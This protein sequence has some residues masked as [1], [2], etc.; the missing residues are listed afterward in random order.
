MSEGYDNVADILQ[1]ANVGFDHLFLDEIT[2]AKTVF[3]S[4]DSPFHL[5]G[6]GVCS[7]LE[8]SLGMESTMMAEANA[9]LSNAEAHAKRQLKSASKANKDTH[10]FP[11]GTLWELIHADCII[12]LGLTQALSE[13][14]TGYLQCLYSINTAHSKYL[15]LYKVVFPGGLDN[16]S[17]PSQ[18]SPPS[19]SLTPTIIPSTSSR[20]SLFSRFLGNGS[21]S[22]VPS[23]TPSP[24]PR[25]D[26]PPEET[27]ISGTAFGYGLFNLV[28]SMF[29]GKVKTVVGFFGY[30]Y[31]RRIAL[32]ALAVSAAKSDVH[33]IFAGLTLMAYYGLVLLL[34]GYQADETHILEQYRAIVEKVAGKFPLGSLWILNKA[35]I[36]RMSYDADG[37]IQVLQDGLKLEKKNKFK[38]ADSLLVFELAW[39]LLSQRRYQEAADMFMKMGKLNSWSHATYHF[40]AAG[41]YTEMGNHKKAQKLLDACPALTEKRKLGATKYLPTEIF[42]LRKLQFYK[43]KQRRRTGSEDNY[44]ESIR[45]STAE[46]IAIFWST[47][48]RISQ[49]VALSH[50]EDLS[51]LTPPVS[52]PSQYILAS[53]PLPS[54]VK[55]TPNDLD[56]PDEEAIRSLI[57][58]TVHRTVGDFATSRAFLEDSVSKHPQVK[59]STWVG[60]VA[61]FELAVLDLKEVEDEERAGKLSSETGKDEVSPAGVKRWEQAIE[62]ATAKLDRAMSIS[63]KDV[64]M[65]ARLD[66]RIM[67]LKDEMTLKREML[68]S[69]TVP[70]SD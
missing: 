14:Y 51:R 32:Q 60:G 43:E 31:N 68:K 28:L 25:P 6:L 29:P 3:Q 27:V 40:I 4:N 58:G 16:Y 22:N 11:P 36:L 61:L 45:I 48:S 69:F 30:D 12:L 8:A 63:G 59:C 1:E 56:T 70:R 67:M 17:T 24:P 13:S 39:T 26:G 64:D 42:I 21:N 49:D 54:P 34:A 65:S 66:S 15:K 55:D 41:C 62:G 23:R 44:A 46:E 50:V 37:A 57:L 19:R 52:I 7:F 47:H 33:S 2:D 10:R 20:P 38:Q 9:A 5:L 35:K 18:S 53:S